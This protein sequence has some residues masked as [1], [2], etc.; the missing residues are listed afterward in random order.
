[1][2]TQC[3]QVYVKQEIAELINDEADKMQRSTSAFLKLVIIDYLKK[4]QL[5]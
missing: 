5:I 4:N 3:L 2:T 1:M